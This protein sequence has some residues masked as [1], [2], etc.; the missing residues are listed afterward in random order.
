MPDEAVTV[1]YI[2]DNVWIVGS[3]E[4]VAEKLAKL[5]G[6]VGGFGVLLRHG[7]RMGAA[8]C[9]GAVV[10]LAEEERAAAAC[11]GQQIEANQIPFP[12]A[13]LRPLMNGSVG[14]A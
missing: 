13:R 2:A 5:H 14:A 1:D 6:D 11:E 12:S 8:R 3:A 7:A 10:H 9:L 4:D